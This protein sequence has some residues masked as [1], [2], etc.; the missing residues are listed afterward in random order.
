MVQHRA[1]CYCTG[2]TATARAPCGPSS[3]T[4]KSTCACACRTSLAGMQQA[5]RRPPHDVPA[6]VVLDNVAPA[7]AGHAVA[8]MQPRMH[9][10]DAE[11]GQTVRHGGMPAQPWHEPMSRKQALHAGAHGCVL[12]CLLACLHACMH[13]QA[14]G[15]RVPLALCTCSEQSRPGLTWAIQGVEEAVSHR[16]RDQARAVQH[17]L[18]AGAVWARDDRLP[19]ARRSARGAAQR[20]TRPPSTPESERYT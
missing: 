5:H 11:E 20:S 3:T 18:N 9:G 10:R 4:C 1:Y 19:A 16:Q 14:C 2:P 17:R 13:G 15:T 8:C 12:A 6:Q 7:R